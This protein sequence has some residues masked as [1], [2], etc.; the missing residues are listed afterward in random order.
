MASNYTPEYGLNQWSLEDSVIMEEFNTDNRKIEQ[1]LLDLKAA[2]PKFQSGSYVGT[3]KY[4]EATPTTLTFD[5]EP[6]M[7]ILV[8]GTS[9]STLNSAPTVCI[10][11]VQQMVVAFDPGSFTEFR[12]AK[13]NMIWDGTT[14]CCYAGQAA[15]QF[16]T[17]DITYHYLASG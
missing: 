15:S 13:L 14:F 12:P 1:A 16:N 9:H 5:F 17:Q 8:Q 7:V 11:G 10:R 6:Q 3:G 4:G 2:L